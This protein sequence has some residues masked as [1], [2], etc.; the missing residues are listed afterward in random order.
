M[1]AAPLSH[2]A[3]LQINWNGKPVFVLKALIS[4]KQNKKIQSGK[5]TSY[6]WGASVYT[7]FILLH[8]VLLQGLTQVYTDG[9]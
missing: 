2:F 3:C 1:M 6:Q 4:R 9:H 5:V 8:Y 7:T